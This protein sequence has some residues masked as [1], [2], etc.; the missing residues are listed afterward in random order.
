MA[1]M[2]ISILRKAAEKEEPEEKQ[3]EGGGAEE[4]EDDDKDYLNYIRDSKIILAT[5]SIH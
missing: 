3:R 2:L 1:T 4:A 5:R